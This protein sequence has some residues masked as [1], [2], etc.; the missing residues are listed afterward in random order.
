MLLLLLLLVYASRVC[1]TPRSSDLMLFCHA[2]HLSVSVL[3]RVRDLRRFSS[4]LSLSRVRVV[5]FFKQLCGICSPPFASSSSR[6]SLV[7]VCSNAIFSAY[8]VPS[9]V[10]YSPALIMF[11]SSIYFDLDLFS[12]QWMN[13]QHHTK[14]ARQE[15]GQGRQ[16]MVRSSKGYSRGG[17]CLSPPTV[18][19]HTTPHRAA[20]HRTA[21]YVYHTAHLILPEG[22]PVLDDRLHAARHARDRHR[23]P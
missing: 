21:P 12:L 20:P 16:R 11:S 13:Q 2:C 18:Q 1:R 7:R 23:D 4:S 6:S 17:T 19:N 14:A 5:Y 10:Y 15:Q 9:C 3:L 8:S 22:V